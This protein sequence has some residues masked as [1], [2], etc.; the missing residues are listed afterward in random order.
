MAMSVTYATV[1]G[2]LVEENRGG[3]VTEYVPDT[4]GN[5]I[6]TTDESGTVTSTTTYWPFGEV[7]SQTGSNPS[8]WGFCG[9]W[10]YLTDA[11]SRMYVRARYYRADASRWLTVDPVWPI[12]QTYQYVDGTPTTI[13][14]RTGLAGQG[15]GAALGAALGGCLVSGG[16]SLIGSWIR[17]DSFGVAACKAGFACAAGAILAAIAAEIPWL[18]KCLLGAL[19]GALAG[20]AATVCRER[21]K[22]I[23]KPNWLCLAV[24]AIVSAVL[25]CVTGGLGDDIQKWLLRFVNGAIQAA[26]GSICSDITVGRPDKFAPMVQ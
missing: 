6:M 21:C 16:I 19:S 12:E 4:L 5:V 20:I 9:V 18:A 14:D 22:P 23:G 24:S 1:H 3:L 13:T 26:V 11:V 7:R 10:G 25:G 2:R 17:G 8:P 15:L